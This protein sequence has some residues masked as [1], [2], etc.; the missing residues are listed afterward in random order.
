MRLYAGGPIFL[1][2]L[3]VFMLAGIFF[4]PSAFAGRSSTGELAFYPCTKCHPV[5]VDAGGNPVPPLPNGFKKHTI[6]LEVHDTLGKD[7]KACLMCHDDPSRNPGMLIAPDGSLIDITGDVSRVCQRCHFEK[8][9]E[10]QVGVHGKNLP[11]C[12]AAGC[13]DPHTPSWIYV[14]ALPPFLGSGFEVQAVGEH[15]LFKPL[16]GPPVYPP[17]NTP[18]SLVVVAS[19]GAVIGAGTLG[20][21][22]MGRSKR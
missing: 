2:A 22:I 1:A 11:K 16:A 9:R 17:V 8:Y 10:W 12:T 7:E 4:A 21:L 15:E 19:I 6:T 5:T 18:L 13:H 14:A 20:L 3:A